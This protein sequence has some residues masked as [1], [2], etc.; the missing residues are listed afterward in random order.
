VIAAYYVRRFKSFST[1]HQPFSKIRYFGKKKTKA[2]KILKGRIG[3]YPST[4]NEPAKL[5]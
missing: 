2:I 4:Q 5:L 3:T 1:E